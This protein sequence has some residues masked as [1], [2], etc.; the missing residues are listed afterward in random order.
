MIGVALRPGTTFVRSR[1]QL[2]FG[3]WWIV[4]T[5]MML[6]TVITVFH[7]KFGVGAEAWVDAAFFMAMQ[8]LILFDIQ[9]L[10]LLGS[11]RLLRWQV[12]WPDATKFSGLLWSIILLEDLVTFYPA[13]KGYDLIEF[14]IS[15]VFAVWYVAVMAIGVRR[16]SGLN[17]G[18]SLLLALLAGL[19]WRGAIFWLTLYTRGFIN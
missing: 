2:R 16:Y 14:S 13:M 12:T 17:S 19:T 10:M 7:P 4:L 15:A 5:V 8:D 6:E 3:Y 11:G 9:A 1:E 18:K